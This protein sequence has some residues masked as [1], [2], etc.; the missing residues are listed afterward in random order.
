[1]KLVRKAHRAQSLRHV[2]A[3]KLTLA[4]TVLQELQEG[5]SVSRGVISRAIRDLKAI[6]RWVDRRG[7]P[8]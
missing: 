4:L 5:K 6:M 7:G 2:A 1:M 3:N 8:V